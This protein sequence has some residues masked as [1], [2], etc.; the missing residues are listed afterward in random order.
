[1]GDSGYSD[2]HRISEDLEEVIELVDLQ[3]MKELQRNPFTKMIPIKVSNCNFVFCRLQIDSVSFYAGGP[4][5]I[6]I[7]QCEFKF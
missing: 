6:W 4:S 3:L 1:M 2:Y 5:M 7:R